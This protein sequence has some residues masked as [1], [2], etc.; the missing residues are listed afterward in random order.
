MT[1][2]PQTIA[3]RFDFLSPYAY[4]AWHALTRLST[5]R[6]DVE[7]VPVPTV[8]AALLNAAGQRGPA[9]I[10][11]KRPYVFKDALRGAAKLGLPLAPPPSHPFHPLL[12]LRVVCAAPPADKARIIT[13]FF[14]VAWGGVRVPDHPAEGLDVPAVVVTALNSLG[15]DGAA[16][17]YAAQT[18]AVKAQLRTNSD[19]AIAAGVFGVPTMMLG[20]ELFWGFDAIGYLVDA[21]DG[22]DPAASA[23]LAQWAALPATA[24]RA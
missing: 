9:E 21:L 16:L 14:D 6:D 24:K 4:L 1:T 22:N 18:D 20:G 23:D 3:F 19:D 10:P 2:A 7:I 5:A 8:L 12:S 17:V 13:A 15:L 11:A